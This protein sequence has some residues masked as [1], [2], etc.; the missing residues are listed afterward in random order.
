MHVSNRPI[1]Y[2]GVLLID[3]VRWDS[4]DLVVLRNCVSKV[5]MPINLVGHLA[6]GRH[7]TIGVL[8]I[9]PSMVQNNICFERIQ[10]SHSYAILLYANLLHEYVANQ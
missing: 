2:V 6:N 10:I 5:F 3:V 8:P 7:T 4:R 9:L 1:E